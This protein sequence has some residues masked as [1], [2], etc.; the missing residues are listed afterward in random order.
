MSRSS[1]KSLGVLVLV[2]VGTMSVVAS[3]AQAKWLLLKNGQSVLLLKLDL[4]L[5]S[6]ELLVP[7][8]GLAINCEGGSGDLHLSMLEGHS[9][10][11]GSA[12]GTLKECHD[13]NFGEVC[14]VYGLAQHRIDFEA[15]G[16]AGMEGEKVSISLWNVGL[17]HIEFFGEECP[18]TELWGTVFGSINL[19]VLNPLQAAQAH[20]IQ[21]D[22]QDLEFGESGPVELHDGEEGLVTGSLNEIFGSSWAIHL[23]GL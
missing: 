2:V 21:L 7:E 11:Y 5:S 12:S 14:D 17:A 8:L 23:V 10:I 6:T 4:T 22:E 15:G 20:T 13:L 3:S 9:S 1:L 18:L 19:S 16:F